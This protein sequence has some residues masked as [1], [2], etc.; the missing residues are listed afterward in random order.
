MFWVCWETAKTVKALS[1]A[2]FMFLLLFPAFPN[3]SGVEECFRVDRKKTH[4]AW[5]SVLRKKG[6]RGRDDRN[7]KISVLLSCIWKRHTDIKCSESVS[8]NADGLTSVLLLE[9]WGSMSDCQL[10]KPSLSFLEG[11][12][13]AIKLVNDSFKNR[14]CLAWKRRDQNQ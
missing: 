14:I 13:S 4:C 3:E 6:W 5:R 7:E 10:L 1:D 12:T 9:E 11:T 8:L 2:H